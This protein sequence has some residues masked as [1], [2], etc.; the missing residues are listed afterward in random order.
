MANIVQLKRSSVSG[1]VPD[2][3]NVEV[4]EPVVNLADQIIFTKDG[5]GT[6]KVIGAGT[7]S[8]ISEG[9]N[10]YFTNTRAVAA[11][12]AGN[13]ITIESNGR[14]SASVSGSTG[15]FYVKNRQGTN[16][17]IDLLSGL[18]SILTRSGSTVNVPIS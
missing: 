10:L 16:I 18:L 4:G 9:T 14:I 13:N 15:F 17:E 5:S 6:V 11:L 8:N 7:T 12:T 3:A 2:A 1:R